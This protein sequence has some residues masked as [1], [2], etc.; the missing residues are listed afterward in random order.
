MKERARNKYRELS[1]TEKDIK[2]AYGRNR[3]N[4][5]EENKKRQKEYQKSY[6]KA[7]KEV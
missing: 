1:N 3:Y 6:R 7:K 5:S 4:M 2:R